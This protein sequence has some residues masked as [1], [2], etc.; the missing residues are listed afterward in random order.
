[1]LGVHRLRHESRGGGREEGEGCTCKRL[2]EEEL[3][4]CRRA[5]DEQ[6]P[7][8]ERPGG[9]E[10]E[11]E[12]AHDFPCCAPRPGPARGRLDRAVVTGEV[13]GPLGVA[14][15]ADAWRARLAASEGAGVT[16]IVY[17]PA[18]PDIEREL[19]AFARVTGL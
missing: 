17:Q 9:G 8:R 5:G 4:Q 18:G 11:S 13:L 6:R 10:H 14:L 12:P 15:D 16:E 2:Q 7:E 19:T 3:P 1:V